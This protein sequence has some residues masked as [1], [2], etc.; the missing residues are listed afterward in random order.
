MQIARAL[1]VCATVWLL[2]ESPPQHVATSDYFGGGVGTHFVDPSDAARWLS[3]AE[4]DVADSPRLRAVGIKTLLYTDPNR[5]MSRQPEGRA[6][7]SAFA[8]DCAGG[9]IE[10]YRAG[11][12]LMDPH[13][14][15]LL[16]AW[17][18]HAQRYGRAGQFDAIFEDDADDVAYLRGMPCRYS[19]TDWLQ[20]TIAMQQA[21]GYP[22]VYN[23]LSNFSDQTISPA[24]G[25]NATAIGGMMEQC[26]ARSP[27]RPK[28]TGPHWLVTEDTELRMAAEG[29]LFF[30]YGNDTT[31]AV[32]ALDGRL[33][34]Y[35]SFLLGYDP[36]SSVLWEYYQGPSR[37]HVMPET[38]LV[39]LQPRTTPRSIAELRTGAGIYQRAFGA[40]Y[41]A[42]SPQGPCVVAVNPDAQAHPLNLTGYTRTLQISGGGVLDGGVARVASP[43]PPGTLAGLSAVVAFR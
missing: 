32:S 13:S 26:Y 8:H 37:F 16:A 4:T 14:A 9:R 40:C 19:P 31:P 12:Y 28:T 34:V 33:Y 22:I 23:G 6:D 43:G 24:I 1:A 7:E 29:K 39:P 30:C 17:K 20:A 10:A 3:W 36:S 2:A 25:L 38:Q 42:G 18:G 41:L 11:Q 5:T 27:A 21:L 15:A 35:A